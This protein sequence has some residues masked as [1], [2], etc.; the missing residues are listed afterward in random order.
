MR[1]IDKEELINKI[2]QSL[3]A[4][5]EYFKTN[6]KKDTDVAIEFVTKLFLE[7]VKN[8]K[9]IE[10]NNWISCSEGLPE[11]WEESVLQN[12]KKY[13]RSDIVYTT[14]IDKFGNKK[15]G[16]DYTVDG[17]WVYE[18]VIAWMPLLE[19]YKG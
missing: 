19:L 13:M 17:K 3:E 16:E 1:L 11:E 18:N 4:N 12:T 7:L 6:E 15:G 14:Y 9:T 8:E 5:D 2:Q 10:Q